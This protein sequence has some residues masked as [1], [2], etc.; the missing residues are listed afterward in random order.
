MEAD[1]AE[2]RLG[3]KEG[4]YQELTSRT[5][6]IIHNAWP[7]D[8][9]LSLS[10]FEPQLAGCLHLLT[11]ATMMPYLRNLS[12]VSSIGIASDWT[13]KRSTEVPESKIEDLSVAGDMGYSQSKLL[14]ELIFAHGCDNL[15]VP[16]SICRVGQIAGPVLS[17]KGMWSPK[18]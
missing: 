16:V 4:A 7:V 5:T 8:F 3:L 11:L 15:K 1:L 2:D 9:N 14:A 6:H 10:S 18:E 12:F 17:P 13:K